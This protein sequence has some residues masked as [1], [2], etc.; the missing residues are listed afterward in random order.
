[1]AVFQLINLMAL[2]IKLRMFIIFTALLL[3]G[4]AAIA[5]N[6]FNGRWY[7]FAKV[8]TDL[9]MKPGMNTKRAKAIICT[10][11]HG[12]DGNNDNPDYP[13]LAG[14]H[15]SYLIK[16]LT[17]FKKGY[18]KEEHMTAMA[19]AISYNDIPDIAHYFSVQKIKRLAPVKKNKDLDKYSSIKKSL[20][21]KEGKKLYQYGNTKK[22][23]TACASCHGING[24]GLASQQYPVL[25]GQHKAYLL[26]ALRAF[27]FG[28]RYND[29]NSLMR[30]IVLK[31]TNDDIKALAS[32]LA[33]LE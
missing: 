11:C 13:R 24:R 25:A 15:K 17:D 18:R 29:K 19:G 30:N 4:F 1:M 9:N 3:Q 2:M 21:L 26:K 7:A 31:L 6:E 22:S 33:S 14:Q 16:Q 32:Y 5:S 10:G 8:K 27:R 12:A 28:K 20:F 23:I